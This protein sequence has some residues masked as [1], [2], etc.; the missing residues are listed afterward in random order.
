ML[1][2]V[3]VIYYVHVCQQARSARSAGNSAIENL[4]IIIIIIFIKIS[5]W[6]GGGVISDLL[7]CRVFQVS[8]VLTPAHDTQSTLDCYTE[9]LLSDWLE[10]IYFK[11]VPLQNICIRYL[12]RL[13]STNKENSM[14]PARHI[15]RATTEPCKLPMVITTWHASKYKEHKL[16]WRHGAALKKDCCPLMAYICGELPFWQVIFFLSFIFIFTESCLLVVYSFHSPQVLLEFCGFMQLRAVSFFSEF[17][18]VLWSAI[19]QLEF[20]SLYLFILEGSDSLVSISSFRPLPGWGPH[21]DNNVYS[22]RPWT[23]GKAVVKNPPPPFFPSL[24]LRLAVRIG[25]LVAWESWAQFGRVGI[26]VA[27]RTRTRH[28]SADHRE[29]RTA[30]SLLRPSLWDRP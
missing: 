24:T 26:S 16:H 27:M 13:Q 19:F 20:F 5:G 21:Q 7:V 23:A 29:V 14:A 1:V 9:K 10:I 22:S 18:R 15:K 6:G 3:N 12:W 2:T 8:L 30:L 17:F 28:S 25:K 4:C 11:R